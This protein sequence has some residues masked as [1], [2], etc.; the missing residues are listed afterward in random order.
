MWSSRP[1]FVSSTFQDMQAERDH[2]RNFVFPAIEERLQAR[3]RHLEWVD[4]RIGVATASLADEGERELQ[5][6][7]VCFEEVRR[8][9]PFL[10]VLLGDR[11]GWVPPPDR[12][13]AAACEAGFSG[14][15]AGRSVTDLEIDLGVLQSA[16]Q[17]T[18]SFFYFR[19]P[20]PYAAMTPEFVGRY[21]DADGDA[22]APFGRRARELKERIA[23]AL[24]DR[25]R[26]YS[27]VWDAG[28]QRVTGL[29]TWG[30]QVVEDLWSD[31]NAQIAAAP[32]APDDPFESARA[33]QE[34]FF[35]DASRDFVGR[36]ALLARALTLARSASDPAG[37]WALC[38]EGPAGSGKSALAGQLRRELGASGACV[39]V[40]GASAGLGAGS[41]DAM[42]RRWIATLAARIGVGVSTLDMST[43]DRV[44]QT[45]GSLLARVSARE[46]VVVVIDAL[47]QFEVSTR[48]RFA[49]WLPRDW[50]SNA[51]LIATAIPCDASAALAG[52]DGVDRAAMPLQ[53]GP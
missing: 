12:V 42:L 15:T 21:A 5:I 37:S 41:V 8:C 23:R 11:Y 6:L 36:T 29:D 3:G 27:A 19:D 40:H 17:Q 9:R 1:V 7:K 13:S 35:A 51:R 22:A 50:P 53:S 18:R 49:T 38:I 14:D 52:R 31:I 16:D 28:A 45:F 39:L 34:R 10:I 20:L 2:L 24:P 33:A 26:R 44:D 48:G 43:A 4:L 30:Q 25:V 46:R 47:D 32:A